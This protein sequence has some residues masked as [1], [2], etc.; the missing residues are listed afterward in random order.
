MEK[1]HE[2]EI[3]PE[4]I[5]N[6]KKGLAN[7]TDPYGRRCY[8]YAAHWAHLMDQHPDTPVADMADRTSKIADYDGI[9]GYMYGAAVNILANCWKRGEELK[10][11]HNKKWGY[12]GDDGVVNPALLRIEA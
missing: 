10:K 5:Q 4:Q 8:T 9:T 12:K 11:W 1:I 7:N 3:L 2:F 6:C